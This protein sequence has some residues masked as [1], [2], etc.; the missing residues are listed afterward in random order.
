ML[1]K[2]VFITASAGRIV[3]DSELKLVT[4]LAQSLVYPHLFWAVLAPVARY[5]L[6]MLVVP[7]V[8]SR[9]TGTMV[10]F[11]VFNAFTVGFKA[12]S[13]ESFHTLI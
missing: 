4:V 11:N 7:D 10:W 8:A 2:R 13:F 1:A 12:M 3:P 5:V 9:A 6:K